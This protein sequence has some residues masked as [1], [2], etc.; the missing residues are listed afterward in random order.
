MQVS[1]KQWRK[2]GFL[3]GI[4]AII[5]PISTLAIATPSA[6]TIFRQSFVNLSHVSSYDIS[7]TALIT[8]PTSTRSSVADQPL[9]YDFFN[10][11]EL[12]VHFTGAVDHKQN[13]YNIASTIYNPKTNESPLLEIVG[14]QNG[15][16]QARLSGLTLS[17]TTD[18]TGILSRYLNTWIHFDGANLPGT[19]SHPLLALGLGTNS[20]VS[21]ELPQKLSQP[22]D[23]KKIT[24][25]NRSLDQAFW[26]RS[27]VV[28]KRLN[29]AK[30][31]TGAVAYRLGLKINPVGLRSFFADIFSVVGQKPTT[32][33]IKDLE[34]ALKGMPL[35]TGEMIVS[36]KDLLPEILTFTIAGSGK[37]EPNKLV[38]KVKVNFE[39][40]GSGRTIVVPTVSKDFKEVLNE[41]FRGAAVSTT[42][43][44]ISST[45]IFR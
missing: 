38:M 6:Q 37:T 18:E 45:V 3:G 17:T 7:G 34:K 31:H 23:Q 33:E 9:V 28:A 39:H 24:E 26:K 42:S 22:L 20:R 8:K 43:S 15:L 14:N 19:F 29:D 11:N 36:K 30:D 5:I 21:S 41:I 13:L 40:F 44:T 35:V 10:G 4:A 32:S 27:V 16:L 2:I 25:V 12:R 1:L